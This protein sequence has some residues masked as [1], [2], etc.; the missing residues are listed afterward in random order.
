MHDEP[1]L[2]SHRR[3]GVET[4]VVAVQNVRFGDGSYPV[5]AGP[6]VV[7]GEAELEEVARLVHRG[8]ASVLRAGTFRAENSPYGFKGLG[9][10]GLRLL[11]TAGL[12]V[13]LPTMTEVLEPGH[14][15]VIAEHVDILEI[16]AENMQNFVLLQ[17]AAQTQ[18]P[19]VLQR[20]PSATIDEWLMAAEYI[21]AEDNH[22]VVLCERGSRTFDPRTTDTIDISAVPVVQRISH[23]P[24]LI[25][26]AGGVGGADIAT[27]LALAGRTVGADGLILNVHA[28]PGD[29]MTGGNH[30][31]A[32][33]DFLTLM[34]SL[35]IPL[36][37]DEIDRIDREIIKLL[38]SR[39]MKS[40][41]IGRIKAGRGLEIF[42]PDREA[43]LL[44]EARDDAKTLGVDPDYVEQIFQTI[45]D[46]SKAAQRKAVEG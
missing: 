24:V 12:E 37:R 46:H 11:Q 20:G 34:E 32:P 10:E 21:L 1:E 27:P 7:E 42:S 2:K 41:E 33:T 13:G 28:V 23:L 38:R 3:H 25:N 35:G 39:L 8:G 19:V 44:N 30:H 40:V 36:L 45:L 6:A 29:A 4:T 18:R 15:E 43:E 22:D 9:G 14:A 31:L 26:P 16:G 5:I 17:A